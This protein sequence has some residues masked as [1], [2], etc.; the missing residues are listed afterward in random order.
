MKNLYMDFR[1]RVVEF[2]DLQRVIRMFNTIDKVKNLTDKQC[3][4]ITESIKKY[5]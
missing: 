2:Q 1:M 4:S 5:F 3:K